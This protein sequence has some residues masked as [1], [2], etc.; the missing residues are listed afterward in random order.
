[1]FLEQMRNFLNFAAK[2]NG[3]AVDLE[4]GILSVRAAISAQQSLERHCAID[5]R[6]S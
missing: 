4:T 3:P 1:M 2:K 5:L 6:G